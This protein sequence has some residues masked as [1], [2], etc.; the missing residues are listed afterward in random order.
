MANNF[1]FKF[2]FREWIVSTAGMDPDIRGWYINL[3]CHQADKQC[4]PN[5]IEK[6]ADLAGVTISQYDRFRECFKHTLSA[7]FKLNDNGMLENLKLKSIIGEEKTYK[8]IQSKRATVGVFIKKIR[9]TNDFTDEVWPKISS[10][11]MKVDF[12]NKS[13]KEIYN[14]LSVRFNNMVEAINNNYIYNYNNNYK[15]KG[16]VG[17]KTS[18]NSA[19]D[20]LVKHNQSR[21]EQFEMAHKKTFGEDWKTYLIHF[22][23]NV[24]Q[25]D[26]DYDSNKL[27]SELNRLKSNWKFNKKKKSNEALTDINR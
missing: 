25:K 27:F 17:E 14:A 7:K 21:L 20:F 23:A 18:S 1:Y 26:I 19:Y 12:T 13:K 11:L 8:S 5:E 4:L 22:E 2:F 16:G 15:E 3:L 6:L 10:D 9:K 24:T